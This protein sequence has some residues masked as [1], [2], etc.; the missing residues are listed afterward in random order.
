MGDVGQARRG[1]RLL[2]K[3]SAV[4]CAQ[5]VGSCDVVKDWW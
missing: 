4:E 3:L 1:V 5:K 2:R